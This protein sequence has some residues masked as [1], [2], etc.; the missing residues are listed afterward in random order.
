M[1]VQPG[2]K[3]RPG[4]AAVALNWQSISLIVGR[5]GVRFPL[6]AEEDDSV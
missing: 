4:R 3:F 2:R 5:K 6:A 1:T